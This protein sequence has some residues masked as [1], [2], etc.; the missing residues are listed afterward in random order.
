MVISKYLTE[1]F[2]QELNNKDELTTF[3]KTSQLS[4]EDKLK[5]IY[6]FVVSSQAYEPGSYIWVKDRITIQHIDPKD[7]NF[8]IEKTDGPVFHVNLIGW[9]ISDRHAIS[10]W[11]DRTYEQNIQ[12]IITDL[13]KATIP[14]RLDKNETI[15]EAN[16][17]NFLLGEVKRST[18]ININLQIEVWSIYDVFQHIREK[19]FKK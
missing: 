5:H 1:K 12:A 2:K 7:K 9:E 4:K 19:M 18:N 10:I 14:Y 13:P 16:D 15:R 8:K 17:L 11:N 6:V 3:L